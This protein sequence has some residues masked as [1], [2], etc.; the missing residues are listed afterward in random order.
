MHHGRTARS[1]PNS[2]DAKGLTA[3]MM[4]RRAG[5][6]GRVGGRQDLKIGSGCAIWAHIPERTR[7]ITKSNYVMRPCD[8]KP[9]QSFLR[10]VMSRHGSNVSRRASLPPVALCTPKGP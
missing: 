6:C 4:A 2:D 10:T 8:E 9:T 3:Q 7:V 1:W 5:V